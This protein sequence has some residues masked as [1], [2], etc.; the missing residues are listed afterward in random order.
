M[1]L[2]R[3]LIYVV[4]LYG[5]MAVVGLV[6][7]P[8]ALVSRRAALAA[9]RLWTRYALW[10]LRVIC[11]ARVTI[12]GAPIAAPA[13]YA[14]KHQAMLDTLTPFLSLPEPAIVLKKELLTMPVFGWFAQR[15]GMIAID[16]EAQASALRGMLRAARARAA[17]GRDIVIF[18]EGTRQEIGAAPDYKPGVAA[19][20]RDLDLPCVPIAV[21]TGLVWQAHGV[22]RRPGHAVIK[23]LDPIPPGLSRAEFMRELQERIERETEALVARGRA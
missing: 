5:G 9:P 7:L 18:P 1:T 16:R 15:C 19:L 13:L 17:E 23:F 21:S 10:A 2:I 3:S 6:C 20:Y 8:A 14:S 4:A 11:G 22:L 12:E